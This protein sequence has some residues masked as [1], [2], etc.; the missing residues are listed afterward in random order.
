MSYQHTIKGSC[1]CGNIKFKLHTNVEEND[2]PLRSCVC[3]F[4]LK[5]NGVY[6]SLADSEL[7]FSVQD[8]N[9]V[10]RYQFGHKTADFFVCR[11]CGIVPI[12]LSKIDERL[13]GIVNICASENSDINKTNHQRKDFDGESEGNRLER[14]KKFWIPNVLEVDSNKF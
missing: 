5:Q 4:C 3:T 6:T 13:Y 7:V 8:S 10:N 2:L 14:R 9:K 12:I 1:H 11:T